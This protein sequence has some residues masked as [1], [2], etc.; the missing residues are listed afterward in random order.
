M[1]IAAKSGVG[2][3]AMAEALAEHWAEHGF[4]VVFYHAEIDPQGMLD[5]RACRHTHVPLYLLE[6]GE[7]S[8]EEL[9]SYAD[10]LDK[11]SGEITYVHCPGWKA[12]QIA[13]HVRRTNILHPVDVV[14]VDYLQ[15]LTYEG[16]NSY[17]L[18]SAQARGAQVEAFKTTA[19]M[20]EIPFVLLSQLNREG[21]IRDSGE[22]EEKSNIRMHLLRK[23]IGESTKVARYGED[24]EDK[25]AELEPEAT[26][27]VF[28]NTFGRPFTC[29]LWFDGPTYSWLSAVTTKLPDYSVPKKVKTPY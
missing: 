27:K 11:W 20:L 8:D 17:G 18:T 25:E 10:R 19:E 1:L 4:H 21:R 24:D 9:F 3:T 5:R 23:P 14:I 7:I 2:K 13:S 16:D 26:V 28:K 22:I 12:S 6:R 29:K 15:K